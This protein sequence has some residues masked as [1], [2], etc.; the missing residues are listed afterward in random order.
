[1]SDQQPLSNILS[2]AF[3]GIF[4][5]NLV[6]EN[7]QLRSTSDTREARQKK[8]EDSLKA[9]EKK[10]MDN[11]QASG[12]EMSRLAAANK[13]LTHA[14]EEL[15]ER[16]TEAVTK[17]SKFEKDSSGLQELVK[18]LTE[19]SQDA[20]SK[21]LNAFCERDLEKCRV[22]ELEQQLMEAK[23]SKKVLLS[24]FDAIKHSRDNALSLV[25]EM[26]TELKCGD[27]H[28]HKLQT[29]LDAA[30]ITKDAEK[31]RAVE[32]EKELK[33]A[34]Q[35]NE[36]IQARFEVIQ[37]ERCDADKQIDDFHA[38]VRAHE[39]LQS[40]TREAYSA[41]AQGKLEAE[42]RVSE[43]ELQLQSQASEHVETEK[44]LLAQVKI[45][46]NQRCVAE[47]S[48]NE[49][50]LQVEI[51]QGQLSNMTTR[52]DEWK[53]N[54]NTVKQVVDTFCPDFAKLRKL[55][56][57]LE[58]ENNALKAAKSDIEVERNQGQARI[59]DLENKLGELIAQHADLGDAYETLA[60]D[61]REDQS[62]VTDLENQVESLEYA[63]DSQ[64]DEIGE[65]LSDA[66]HSEDEDDKEIT[67][68]GAS[69][70]ETHDH[71]PAAE[72]PE[73]EV[74]EQL[75]TAAD[76]EDIASEDLDSEVDDWILC[77][78]PQQGDAAPTGQKRLWRSLGF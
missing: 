27:K 16:L 3:G 29:L 77:D 21:Y 30:L 58:I 72:N 70:A 61:R 37:M 44:T 43:L 18:T 41:T 55:F 78:T 63:L 35:T 66:E 9:S 62:R 65:G 10:L 54:Y 5:I 71:F 64:E 28:A 2:K 22:F 76:S 34:V 74:S 14:T 12:K 40:S 23:K 1:M 7:Q 13:A 17:A 19:Q 24:Q 25:E 68:A 33:K 11:M 38:Q 52:C 60:A 57:D 69:V 4:D 48:T 67:I 56:H 53:Q 8:L 42:N 50:K 26:T 36:T 46:K 59:T 32:L 49:Y 15:R 20:R 45:E 6:L 75:S 39:L 51:L 31:Y 73:D 47:R